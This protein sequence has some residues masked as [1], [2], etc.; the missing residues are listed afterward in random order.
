MHLLRLGNRPPWLH[1]IGQWHPHRLEDF[2]QELGLLFKA[3]NLSLTEYGAYLNESFRVSPNPATMSDEDNLKE[4]KDAFDGHSITDE[5]G[6]IAET[7]ATEEVPSE[8]ETPVTETES[9]SKE[10]QPEQETAETE[11][12]VAED[13]DG[14]KY[15]P[16]RRFKDVYAKLKEAER[17]LATQS[18]TPVQTAPQISS[19]NPDR[20]ALLETET[21]H[22]ALPQFNPNS[23]DYSEVLDEMGA[24]I[25]Q[26]SFHFD[27]RTQSVI[28]TITKLEAARRAID[29][30]KKLLG[31]QEKVR[32]E[33]RVVKS[34][35]SDSGITSASRKVASKRPDDMSL[36]EM[37]EYL[38]K[39]NAW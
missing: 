9:P 30:A 15:V 37:E 22:Q 13:E 7:T 19:T 34:Q 11:P 26:S 36:A 5:T 2:K 24:E 21:L 10:T 12:E 14:K 32:A 33:V 1:Q 23:P 35:Q 17:K 38:K 4:L 29:R 28:P 18:P 8:T 20:L 3:L 6:Q 27:P 31:T 16:E 25:Y 39:N